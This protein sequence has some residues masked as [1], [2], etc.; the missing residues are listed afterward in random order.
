M[1]KLAWWEENLRSK[2]VNWLLWAW[3]IIWWIVFILVWTVKQY[4]N[5]IEVVIMNLP[6]NLYIS[7]K[8]IIKLILYLEKIGI[9][10]IDNKFFKRS[11]YG[12]E[13]SVIH[14]LAKLL[15]VDLIWITIYFFNLFQWSLL[16]WNQIF[17][18]RNAITHNTN[19]LYI[20]INLLLIIQILLLESW[21]FLDFLKGLS[22]FDLNN[23]F[24]F[25]IN[26][27]N[28]FFTL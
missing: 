13:S 10:R 27:Q 14:I 12:Y 8:K 19:S 26:S 5:S 15:N 6:L 23:F 25:R 11:L 7:L 20:K 3:I 18:E 17:K 22:V 21:R 4:I 24:L 16:C 9:Y 28:V 1:N 2:E